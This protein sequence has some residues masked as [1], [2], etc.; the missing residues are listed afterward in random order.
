MIKMNYETFDQAFKN[1]WTVANGHL[2]TMLKEHMEKRLDPTSLADKIDKANDGI[3]RLETAMQDYSEAGKAFTVTPEGD[4]PFDRIFSGVRGAD[5]G[6]AAIKDNYLP[7]VKQLVEAIKTYASEGGEINDALIQTIFTAKRLCEIML[8]HYQIFE[9]G[10]EGDAFL[11]ADAKR[12]EKERGK[13][14]EEIE[15]E[16]LEE[17]MLRT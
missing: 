9:Y 15:R 4:G 10:Q 11:E 3:A 8:S 2:G 1:A 14:P 6:L 5:C 13:T 12:R 16:W 7:L 17:V